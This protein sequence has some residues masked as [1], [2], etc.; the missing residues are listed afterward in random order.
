LLVGLLAVAALAFAGPALGGTG[1]PTG[2]LE[3]C[4]ETQGGL[5]G[6]YEFSF[7]GRT[8]RVTVSN[9]STQPVCTPGQQVPAGQVSVTEK[10]PPD[11]ELC[12]IRTIQPGRLAMTRGPT[13]SVV[14][15]AGG[16][17]TETTLV[18]CNRKAPKGSIAV[19]KETQGGLTGTFTFDLAGARK[20]VKVSKSGADPVCAQRIDVPSGRVNVTETGVPGTALCGVRTLP[21]GRVVSTS[22]TSASVTVLPGELTNVVFCDRP[23]EPGDVEI[24][25]VAGPGIAPGTSFTFTIRDTV[26]GAITK[27][28]VRAGECV[29]AG[30]FG[31]GTVIEVTETLPNGVE[32]TSKTVSPADQGRPCGVARADRL[33]A[34][35]RAGFL[36]R[37]TFTNSSA[38]TKGSLEVCKVAGTGVSPGTPFTFAVRDTAGGPAATVSVPAGQCKAAGEFADGATVEVTETP[39]AGTEVSNRAVLPAERLAICAQP[40]PNRVCATLQA[41]ATTQVRFTNAVPQG[42]LKVCKVGGTGVPDGTPFTF[43]VRDTGTGVTSSVTVPAGQCVLAGQFADATTVEVTELVPVGTEVSNRE[44]SPITW[45]QTCA[46]PQSNRLCARVGGGQVTHVTFTDRKPPTTVPLQLCKVAGSAGIT[47]TYVFTVRVLP[48]GAPQTAT[49]AAGACVNVPGLTVGT[50]VEVTEAVPADET[51][52][53]TVDPADEAR[54]CPAPAAARVCANVT[55]T[56]T[57]VV[58][59]NRKNLTTMKLCKVAGSA[60]ISGSYAFTVRVLPSGTPQAVNVTAGACA[61]VSDLPIGSTVEFTETV[62]AGQAATL[63]VDPP[64]EERAC[65]TPATARIC[66]NAS[67]TAEVRVVA[68]NRK[69]GTL[70]L[71]K[72][73]GSYGVIGTY[74]F[75][76]R[77]LPVGAPQTVTVGVGDCASIG[78]I[79]VGTTVEV[80]EQVPAD[81]TATLAVDPASEERACPTPAAARVCANVSIAGTRVVAT[82]KKNLSPG[83]L[84]LCKI[85]GTGVANGVPFSFLVKALAA[86]TSTTITV[87]TG[88]CETIQGIPGDSLV[89]VTET[90]PPGFPFAPQ[91]AV[92]PAGASRTC[93]TPMPTRA[94]ASV[95]PA[96][97]V[98]MRF[99]NRAPG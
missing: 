46:V 29:S 3:I 73:A 18:F 10:Q 74:T 68:T 59:T 63:A 96:S 5:T 72:V 47:G 1:A 78:D 61:I 12:G 24:C 35:I 79:P 41:G 20:S 13:A 15:P 86:G 94:C 60:G 64:G 17:E 85:A 69:L 70:K 16:P 36:A 75:T 11:T 33:C 23:V 55:S 45:L 77:V 98:E 89:E 22:G 4:K 52:T 71:C 91:I 43:S 66:A 40:Q 38:T 93:A 83:K 8:A 62:P 9:G 6:T 92:D 19:C 99:T 80:T 95:P 30:S 21:A 50:T 37:L 88:S 48:A 84:K 49:V 31:D 28:V 14:I 81:Q 67:G 82:N 53:L 97:T 54:A 90:L 65:P 2:Y 25:K 44:V 39:A 51:A 26:T 87:Q 7:A 58:A 57:R 27:V 42:Q 34:L 32:V 76:V 56:P